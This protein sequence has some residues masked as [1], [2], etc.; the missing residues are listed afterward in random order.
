MGPTLD[1]TVH[2]ARVTSRERRRLGVGR[3]STVVALGLLIVVSL[4]PTPVAAAKPNGPPSDPASP[5][6]LPPGL[7]KKQT[8]APAPASMPASTPTSPT[9]APTSGSPVATIAPATEKPDPTPPPAETSSPTA[10]P[11]S[12]P[13]A[14]AGSIDGSGGSPNRGGSVGVHAG[15]GS[16][17]APADGSTPAEG[18]PL[19][20]H[21]DPA[22][23][24]GVDPGEPSR[25]GGSPA[26]TLPLALAGGALVG[27]LGLI[28]L[29]TGSR[30]HGRPIE[31]VEPIAADVPEPPLDPE[32]RFAEALAAGGGRR[33]SV[34]PAA[35]L[36]LWV[37]RLDPD[38]PVMPAAPVATLDPGEGP[39]S[40]LTS[41]RFVSRPDAVPDELA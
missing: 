15:Q 38:L 3:A 12:A 13:P 41:G 36:P 7:D 26:W 10:V 29:F 22:A 28:I 39:I 17:P 9:A 24:L 14:G 11:R 27:V 32:E 2:A 34:A 30:R 5:P 35:D 8:P 1:T 18:A 6:T 37:R 31:P 19:L 23:G 40:G 16:V 25:G 33:G 21:A 4:F 20:E